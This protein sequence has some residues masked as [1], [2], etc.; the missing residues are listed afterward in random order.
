MKHNCTVTN[1]IFKDAC[2]YGIE[3]HTA[4]GEKSEYA[5][6]SPCKEEVE[7]LASRLSESDDISPIHF[8]D[9]VR[10]CIAELYFS[11]IDANGLTA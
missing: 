11:L 5:F 8:D 10:D 7:R 9:I 6:V 2:F 1:R 4:A 3:I